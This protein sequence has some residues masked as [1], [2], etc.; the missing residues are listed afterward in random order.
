MKKGRSQKSNGSLISSKSPAKQNINNMVDT[1]VTP[2]SDLNFIK[3]FKLSSIKEKVVNFSVFFLIGFIL[4]LIIILKA[5]EEQ[6]NINGMVNK[7]ETHVDYYDILGVSKKATNM[8]IRKSFRKLSL[9]WHPDKNHGCEPCLEKFREISKAY[10]VLGDADKRSIYDS[11]Y[12]GEIEIIP[13]EAVTLTSENFD[14]LV[15]SQNKE[16]WVIQVYTDKDEL[17]HYF[18]PIWEESIEEMGNYYR[19]GRINAHKEKSLLK[20]LPLNVKVFPAIFILT[21][22]Y[23]YEMYSQIFDST[24]ESFTDFLFDSFPQ[25]LQIITSQKSA[26]NWLIKK[27]QENHKGKIIYISEKQE[28]SLI[29]KSVALKW[30]SIFDF[31]FVSTKIGKD[32]L[33]SWNVDIKGPTLALFPVINSNIKVSEVSSIFH[34]S[35]NN[36]EIDK[37]LRQNEKINE[38]KNN[39]FESP[40]LL[41]L[42]V[43]SSLYIIQQHYYPLLDAENVEFLCESNI[44]NRVICLIIIHEEYSQ[45]DNELDKIKLKVLDPLEN[46]RK[47]YQ[48][49]RANQRSRNSHGE[50]NNSNSEEFDE[51]FG[52]SEVFEDEELFIQPVQLAISSYKN[53][54]GSMKKI[55][56]F[57]EF[58]KSNLKSSHTFL[59]DVDGDRYAIINETKHLYEK[60]TQD[61]VFWMRLPLRCT[62]FHE[63]K[64]YSNCL[65]NSSAHGY[66]ILSFF[67]YK[68]SFKSII[69]TVLIITAFSYLLSSISTQQKLGLLVIFPILIAVFSHPSLDIFWNLF[70]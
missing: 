40:Q 17:C 6:Y 68:F 9:R 24:I 37:F 61:E 45:S 70:Y 25:T 69:T 14:T 34:L 43:E 39:L 57:M 1:I 27:S 42:K 52:D 10:E 19:F 65:F 2:K 33:R 32:F 49:A 16:S 54:V 62:T 53:K 5:G 29:I 46:S 7:S 30:S 26:Y 48:R 4:I 60:F 66:S 22:G 28:P 47:R 3:N 38:E 15:K 8:E 56:D 23:Q 51:Y 18:S 31:A 20:Y 21:N 44:L 41:S 59:L 35:I 12:G 67:R 36:K 63:K 13:S 11:N 64:F 55:A 50:T 58:W